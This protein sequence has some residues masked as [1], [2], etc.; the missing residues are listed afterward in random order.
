[1]IGWLAFGNLVAKSLLLGGLICILPGWYF[2]DRVFRITGAQNTAK[3]VKRFYH[4]EVIKILL[5]IGLFI[6]A[7]RYVTL[8]PLAF[9][10]GF[11][12]AQLVYW[13]AP[14]I[15]KSSTT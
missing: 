13:V 11:I 9:F 12:V 6:V 8:I 5:S 1:M 15:L 4:S 3:I 2:I 10:I 14:L 7:I